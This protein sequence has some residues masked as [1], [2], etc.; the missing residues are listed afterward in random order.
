M[1]SV[2]ANKNA[3]EEDLFLTQLL[4]ARAYVQSRR[5]GKLADL[6]AVDQGKVA[7][8]THLQIAQP[9]GQPALLIPLQ[10]VRS[11]SPREIV[12]DIEVS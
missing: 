5:I 11:L 6:V 3:K 2:T 1:K 7:E 9:F 4:G 12:L 10:K 8:V